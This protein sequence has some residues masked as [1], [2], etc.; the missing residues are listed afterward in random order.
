MAT[1]KEFRRAQ[2]KQNHQSG[3]ARSAWFYRTFKPF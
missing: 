3:K 2:R 1:K